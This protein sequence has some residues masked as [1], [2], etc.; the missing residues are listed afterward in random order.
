[1][2][3]TRFFF[4]FVGSR[5]G[6]SVKASIESGELFITDVDKSMTPQF[7]KDEHMKAHLESLKCW[8]QEVCSQAKENYNK[9]S[10]VILKRLSTAHGILCSMCNVGLKGR[11]EAKPEH[12]KMYKTKRH[13]TMK[14]CILVEKTCNSPT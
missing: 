1:M 12:Q 6:Q 4:N 2:R 11:L 13:C 10:M 7:D 8:E 3:V 5:F 14:L 9:L